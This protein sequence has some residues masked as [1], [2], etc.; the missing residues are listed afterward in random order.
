MYL[1]GYWFQSYKDRQEE[2]VQ[3]LDTYG[4][5]DYKETVL[6]QFIRW[7]EKAHHELD[8]TLLERFGECLVG[9]GGMAG[10]ERNHVSYFLDAETDNL[11]IKLYEEP[12]VIAQQGS[13]GHRT[14]E[15]ALALTDYIVKHK[16]ELTADR[17]VELGAGT[18]LVGIAAHQLGVA[19]GGMTILT[20]GDGMVVAQLQQNID[21][22]H[23]DPTAIRPDKLW[24][25]EDSPRDF[26]PCGASTIVACADV[27]Y[28]DELIPE[29]A[30]CLKDFLLLK[31]TK[32]ALLSA[33]MRSMQT[34]DVFRH[35]CV[36]NNIV[37]T[38]VAS[39]SSPFDTLFF[40]PPNSPDIIIFKLTLKC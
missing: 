9:S 16:R 17:F 31:E 10:A 21:L 34:F 18:G 11:Q 25:G 35:T 33:T 1:Q 28:D 15:A 29:L 19:S 38:E 40:I 30:R 22:N 26:V 37:L 36:T 4:R 8:E 32:F 12:S 27:T 6:R 5:G 23:L 24:W 14:W 20:D 2:F 13:T 3:L 39:Y 7:L